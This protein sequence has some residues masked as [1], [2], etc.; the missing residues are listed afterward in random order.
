MS[1]GALVQAVKP[2]PSVSLSKPVAER[3][4]T[5]ESSAPVVRLTLQSGGGRKRQVVE[6]GKMES[7]SCSNERVSLP[8]MTRG[9]SSADNRAR[10]RKMKTPILIGAGIV[11]QGSGVFAT[12]DAFARGILF[13]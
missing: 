10:G 4:S 1:P 5:E 9:V 8:Q 13:I 6:S 7:M 12:D 11:D 2:S 3:A